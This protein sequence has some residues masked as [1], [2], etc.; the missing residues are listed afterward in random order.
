MPILPAEPEM[1]PDNLWDEALTPAATVRRWYCLHTRP[2]QE[3]AT[4]RDLRSAE[5]AF[6]LPQ[7]VREDRTPGGRKIRSVLP[8]FGGYLFLFG[9]ESHRTRALMGN[10]LVGV[11]D[12]TDQVALALDL[13]QIHLM[14]RS[15][16][17]IVPEARAPLGS[18][19]R[20]VTGPL[21]GLV[22]TVVR[23]GKRDQFIAVVRM[24]GSGVAVDL[25]DW[26]VEVLD[27]P[28]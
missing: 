27:R 5:I 6:Y 25:A 16:L 3:K 17:A 13:Q 20:I 21:A 1:Y 11:L 8:L 7:I 4:A 12:V 14:L 15:G 26:Q 10:R 2:R 18:R 22:G 9:D 28:E 23:R 24:L 19:I